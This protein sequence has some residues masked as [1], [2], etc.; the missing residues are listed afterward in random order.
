MAG[1]HP[2]VGSTWWLARK[3]EPA[4]G[5][6]IHSWWRWGDAAS[7]QPRSALL[8]PT[9]FRWRRAA[10]TAVLFQTPTARCR[11]LRQ[12]PVPSSTSR[13]DGRR[14]SMWIRFCS[15]GSIGDVRERSQVHKGPKL[16][17]LFGIS[18]GLIQWVVMQSSG[19]SWSQ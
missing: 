3:G 15:I 2:P 7:Q 4:N 18:G 14:L 9:K 19:K 1:K 8:G 6:A 13:N 5:P 16:L 12:T 10:S 17:H 11:R